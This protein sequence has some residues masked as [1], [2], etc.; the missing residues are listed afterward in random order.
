MMFN[1]KV[2]YIYTVKSKFKRYAKNLVYDHSIRLGALPLLVMYQM[3]VFL[4]IR[5]FS[6]SNTDR[7]YALIGR[8]NQVKRDLFKRSVTVENEPF[9]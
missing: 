7:V 3:L 2:F 6:F 4:S 1:V 8:V 9:C 5:C